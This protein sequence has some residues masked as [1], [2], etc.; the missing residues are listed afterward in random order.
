MTYRTYLGEIKKNHTSALQCLRQTRPITVD[1][2]VMPS[3]FENEDVLYHGKHDLD[4]RLSKPMKMETNGPKK[5]RSK[6]I[7]Q[8]RPVSKTTVETGNRK[9]K[10]VTSY[11][12]IVRQHG[13]DVYTTHHLYYRL[14]HT[15][16][17]DTDN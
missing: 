11:R 15:H 17:E 6:N 16:K 13:T 3:L 1:Y 10:T 7:T 9:D 8:E 12:A 14:M 5:S 4:E 2:L